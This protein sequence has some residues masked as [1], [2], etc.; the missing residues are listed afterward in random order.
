MRTLILLSIIFMISSFA[1]AGERYQIKTKSTLN[2]RSGPGSSYMVISSL[3][4]NSYVD[5][6]DF[7]NG[8]A[9]IDLGGQKG[10]VS[11]KYIQKCEE[12]T[13][14]NKI[15][16][17]AGA[18]SFWEK[19][20]IA[21]IVVFITTFILSAADRGGWF[22]LGLVIAL[23]I[24]ILIYFLSAPTPMWFLSPSYIGWM[25]TIINGFGF[26]MLL[27]FMWGSMKSFLR[28]T[29]N[30]LFREREYISGLISLVFLIL[31]VLA[32]W[33]AVVTAIMELFI[34]GI[35][36]V[37]GSAGGSTYM[38]SFTDRDGNSWDVYRN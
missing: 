15:E 29:I 8:W 17:S 28:D 10:Y 30:D 4:N 7:I 2:V 16:R 13:S 22:T 11:Q 6:E 33:N 3:Q 9:V 1:C 32:M 12:S 23:P 31:Y 36:M 21:I 38:G 24:M 37:I 20:L 5:V 18:F 19:F 26:L 35:L 25:W 34:I 14:S 27:S